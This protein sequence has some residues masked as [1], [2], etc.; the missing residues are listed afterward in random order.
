M[1]L[2]SN[3]ALINIGGDPNDEFYRYKMPPIKTQVTGRGNGIHTHL[4]NIDEVSNSIGHPKE[5]IMK[6]ISYELASN[7]NQKN[8]SLAGNHENFIQEKIMDYINNLVL[9]KKCGNPET[10]YEITGK[11]K[12]IKLFSKCSSCGYRCEIVTSGKE[13]D[14][15]RV[16]KGKN[17]SKIFNSIVKYVQDNPD[18]LNTKEKKEY[19]KETDLTFDES[20]LFD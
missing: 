4:L 14:V 6:F 5:I 19:I 11:K 15:T 7:L 20:N 13:D 3:N 12:R 1:S 10:I 16:I 9:C 2:F 8:E 17:S 18:A